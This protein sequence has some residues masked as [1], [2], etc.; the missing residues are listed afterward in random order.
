MVPPLHCSNLPMRRRS[1]PVKAPFSWPNSSLSSSVLRDGRAVQRQERRLGPGAV[2]VD[3]AGDQ[4]LAG[5][6]LAGDQHGHVLG[7]DAADGLVH[8]AHGRAGADDGPVHV[9]V[10]GGLGDHGRLAHPPGHLQR[11]A[12]HPPQ[13]VRVERLEQVVVGALLHRLDGRV[14][15]LGHGDEDDRDARVDAADLLVDLQAGLVGQAQVEENDV[16][17]PGADP[18]EAFG[19]GG[20]HLD[21]VSRRGERLAHL[22]RD[23]G[24]VIVDEQQVGHGRLHPG[25]SGVSRNWTPSSGPQIGLSSR[26]SRHGSRPGSSALRCAIL[27]APA[28]ADAR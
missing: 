22:L 17:R 6:A 26:R 28:I 8:L 14:R 21:P 20:G 13:L 1:A 15:G 27:F 4:F 10:R 9:G 24:R 12:D 2:L 5:A 25:R 23:Q 19:A 11:L 16:R 18:L 3:G 7:G